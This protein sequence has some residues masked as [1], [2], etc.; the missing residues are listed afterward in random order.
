MRTSLPLLF[1]PFVLAACSDPTA[2]PEV[3][4]IVALY[5]KPAETALSPYPSNRYTTADATT[6]T[7]L[8]VHIGADVTNDQLISSY[9]KTVQQLNEM[10]G[11]STVGGIIVNF[12]GPIDAKSLV[13]APEADP[14][15]LGP[16]LDATDYQKPGSPLYLVN[17]DENSP[18][19]GQTVGLIP[20]W[21]AQEDDDDFPADYTL[22]AEPAIPL[23]QGTKYA[24]VVTNALHA[25]DGRPIDRSPDM[26]A[27]LGAGAEGEYGASVNDAVDEIEKSV[28]IARKD[29]ILASVFTTATIRSGI[30]AMGIAA[31]KAPTP[32][33]SSPWEV[34]QGPEAG[35]RV[36]FKAVYDA[37]DYRG[38]D[39]GTWSFENGVP[40]VQKTAGLEVFLAFSKAEVSGKRPVV[41]YGHGLGGDKDGT[42]GTADRLAGVDPN[43]VAIFGIDSPE[44]GS[45]MRDPNQNSLFAA[46]YFFGIDDKTQ[47]FNIGQA[48]D[49]FRQMSSDQLELVKLINSL[50]TLD[51]LPVG[52]PDGIPDL[53]TS[54]ILY[55][56]HSF[57][58]V[59][60][61]TIMALAPEIKHSVWNVGGDGLMKLLRDSG[62][63][64]LLVNSFRPPG[65]P[66]GFLG[67]FFATT[68]AIVDP[69]DPLNYARYCALEELP[70]TT[71]AKP[72]DILLQVVLNDTIVPNTSSES[73][74]RAMGGTHMNPIRSVSGLPE[75]TGALTGN[76]ATGS[77]L[78]M[79]Q[80]DKINGGKTAIHGD[81][82]FAP[83]GQAQYVEFFKTG[84]ANPHA[85][86][87]PPY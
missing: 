13:L 35:G 70:G 9:E 48:R 34:Q 30:E 26:E 7:G 68:Q 32:V 44:H 66:E 61:P 47:A 21:Y 73:L 22:V 63:F 57:G 71:G 40:V 6:S 53:D 83:E 28:G 80:F 65:T 84:L 87:K 19:K 14:P 58:S 59:Q 67:R 27:L 52:A 38:A 39:T 11:F 45:R 82:I 41:I 78:V 16:I 8:R 77:T 74:A 76:G 42:W 85:T 60:G 62:T 64:G 86:A 23:R 1:A 46:F 33:L 15:L 36:R 25:A 50:D 54:R 75:K 17:V 49:N 55:I 4:H 43:G 31:R 72:R 29:I 20:Q 10:D 69:G 18:E 37:P 5:G 79:S 24:F 56:G 12:S 51:L 2:A 81:L 3:P